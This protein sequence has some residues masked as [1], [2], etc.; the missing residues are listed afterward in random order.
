MWYDLTLSLEVYHGILFFRTVNTNP[1]SSNGFVALMMLL[2]Y[3]MSSMEC[4]WITES[5]IHTPL[6]AMAVC[7]NPIFSYKATSNILPS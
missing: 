6:L 4:L 2:P 3:L 1:M 5:N 7:G